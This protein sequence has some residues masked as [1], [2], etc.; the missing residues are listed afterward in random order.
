MA[1]AD[2]VGAV[3]SQVFLRRQAS[4]PWAKVHPLLQIMASKSI[5]S[6]RADRMG[7]M[8]T[9]KDQT[10]K[11]EGWKL[12]VSMTALTDGSSYARGDP[13]TFNNA[14]NLFHAKVMKPALYQQPVAFPVSDLDV[15]AP[16][17]GSER[18]VDY[19]AQL[20]MDARTTMTD[21]MAADVVNVVPAA[22]D[23]DPLVGDE[24]AFTAGLIGNG[25]TAGAATASGIDSTVQTNWQSK[26]HNLATARL[27]LSRLGKDIRDGRLQ[28][29]GR[30][31]DL[32]VCG[33]GVYDLLIQE[34]EA[35]N[36]AQYDLADVFG[37]D[38]DTSKPRIYL[39]TSIRTIKVEGT[40]VFPD[41]DLDSSSPGTVLGLTLDEVFL[42]TVTGFKVNGW[43]DASL[44]AA[45]DQNRAQI[46]WTGFTILGDRSAHQR[47]ISCATA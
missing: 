10:G 34:A 35:K 45:V 6:G 33:F 31:V 38:P 23:F 12:P 43:L 37:T 41:L 44:A 26:V 29:A 46:K 17:S 39:E 24:A 42:Y 20:M 7:Q 9:M 14:S 36:Q 19:L 5:T 4:R 1:Y 47:W 22:T 25:L 15:F 30:K 13:F 27:T 2:T 21:I 3:A 18:G 32:I 16:A 40:P 11:A 28:V 8:L